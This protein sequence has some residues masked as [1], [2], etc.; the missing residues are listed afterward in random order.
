M[1][2]TTA[3]ATNEAANAAYRS[4]VLKADVA[5]AKALRIS[6][7]LYDQA[8]AANVKAIA[9]QDAAYSAAMEAYSKS[10][11]TVFTFRHTSWD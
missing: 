8:T 1:T 5:Y 7:D 3:N 4:A 2:A 11:S 9:E 6:G 10:T